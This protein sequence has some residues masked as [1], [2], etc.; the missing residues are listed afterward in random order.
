MKC[1]LR[2]YNICNCISV[3]VEFIE[4]INKLLLLTTQPT[5]EFTKICDT[6]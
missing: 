2:F 1:L 3:V 6:I 5:A 4:I